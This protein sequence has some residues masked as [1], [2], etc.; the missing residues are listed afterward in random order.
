MYLYLIVLYFLTSS[1]IAYLRLY[2]MNACL[3][4]LKDQACN[5]YCIR[6]AQ[7]FLFSI[8]VTC[9]GPYGWCCRLAVRSICHIYL[10]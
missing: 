8:F 3:D 6:I 2:D 4:P 7:Y 10:L 9:S 1:V 5:Y